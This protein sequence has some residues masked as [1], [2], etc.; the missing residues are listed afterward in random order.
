M[1]RTA[2]LTPWLYILPTFFFVGVFLIYPVI[3]TVSLSFF[4]HDSTSF[5]GLSNYIDLFSHSETLLVF[6]NNLL[7]LTLFTAVVMSLGLFLAVLT[8]QVS[9]EAL[10][11]AIIFIPMA[12]SFTAAAVIWRFMYIFQPEGF[13]Q[14]GV[15]NALL[16]SAKGSPIAW[17]V[18]TT[19][20]NFALIAAGVWMWTGFALVVISAGLKGIPAEVLEAA[21]VDGANEWQIFRRITFPMLRPVLIVVTVTLTINAL[22]VFDLVYVMTFGNHNTDVI[23]NRMFKEMFTFGNAGRASAIA[24]ILLLAIIPLMLMNVRY[25]R[26]EGAE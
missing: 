11:K 24:T 10:A 25:F 19:V 3:H 5:A 6:R 21:R 17:L 23:A 4:N 22:K 8:N 12:I 18:D 16:V 20:N 14:T 13:T 26:R 7:W 15:I 1:I 9:Y 2:P